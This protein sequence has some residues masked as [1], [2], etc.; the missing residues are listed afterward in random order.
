M[1]TGGATTPAVGLVAQH[2][3]FFDLD[4]IEFPTLSMS[5]NHIPKI[6][7]TRQPSPFCDVV[8]AGAERGRVHTPADRRLP[9]GYPYTL[10]GVATV[11]TA[12]R[13]D[14][15]SA[16]DSRISCARFD[17]E[18]RSTHHRAAAVVRC[19]QSREVSQVKASVNLRK[20]QLHRVDVMVAAL[21]AGGN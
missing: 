5:A 4:G 18:L 14:A 19:A 21:I 17:N 2:P 16:P 6:D 1:E 15:G 3:A 10:L 7:R 11:V 13:A 8:V 9:T 12:V 20:V